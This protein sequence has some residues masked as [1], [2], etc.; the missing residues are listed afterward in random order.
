MRQVFGWEVKVLTKRPLSCVGVPEVDSSAGSWLLI[1][2]VCPSWETAGNES[3]IEFFGS[4]YGGSEPADGRCLFL[5]LN[6]WGMQE[7]KS[8]D[9]LTILMAF[10]TD[11]VKV[12]DI[13]R[14]EGDYLLLF[15]L[16]Y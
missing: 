7:V 14:E 2:Y 15:L 9:L 11:Q 8:D 3:T 6:K 5:K 12:I 13:V 4:R 16:Q 10:I 1:S